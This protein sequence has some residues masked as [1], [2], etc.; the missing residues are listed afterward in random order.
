MLEFSACVEYGRNGIYFIIKICMIVESM[1]NP[2]LGA[3]SR[4]QM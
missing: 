1:Y 2:E 4:M 3:V